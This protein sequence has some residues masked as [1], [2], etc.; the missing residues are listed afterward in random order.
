MGFVFGS[1]F[2]AAASSLE[3]CAG[4]REHSTRAARQSFERTGMQAAGQKYQAAILIGVELIK[5][6][7][8]P[9]EEYPGVLFVFCC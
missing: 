1:F 8:G 7:A 6:F 3:S 2:S 5:D 4:V 9:L